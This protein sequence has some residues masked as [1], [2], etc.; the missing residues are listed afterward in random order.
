MA[1]VK[2]ENDDGDSFGSDTWLSKWANPEEYETIKS[3]ELNLKK[4]DEHSATG[5]SQ[6]NLSNRD[7]SQKNYDNLNVYKY[8]Y[9]EKQKAQKTLKSTR[10]SR[11]KA[12]K[13]EKEQ[14]TFS[15]N[16]RKSLQ[17]AIEKATVSDT[18]ANR[19]KYQCPAC[20]KKHNTKLSLRH[21]FNTTKHV[22]ERSYTEKFLT[23]IVAYKCYLCSKKM[24]CDKSVIYHH[25][26]GKHKLPF[27]D[28]I[29]LP[30]VKV[31][32]KNLKKEKELETFITKPSN[33]LTIQ[34]NVGNFCKFSC[35]RCEYSSLTWRILERHLREKCNLSVQS[36][37]ECVTKV[38]LYKCKVCIKLLL[39]DTRIIA[40]HVKSHKMT[41]CEYQRRHETTIENLFEQYRLNLSTTVQNIAFFK[42]KEL[43]QFKS[44]P[45]L[46]TQIQ[47][48]KDTGNLT[49][50][51][52]PICST[53]CLSSDFF[54]RHRKRQHQMKSKIN[55]KQH[56]IEAPFH[57]CIIC[58]KAVLCDNTYVGHHVKHFHQLKL[59]Q[60]INKF[61]IKNGH[62]N[63]PTFGEYTYNHQ[64]FQMIKTSKKQEEKQEEDCSFILPEDLSSESKESG[65][66]K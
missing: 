9:Q 5:N 10:R 21:H 65:S 8:S 15:T 47:T 17:E 57:S 43:L 53:I 13:T 20:G 18:I 49:S 34:E 30:N 11:K 23:D 32:G 64:V 61:V 36:P 38:S 45:N 62:R 14:R 55:P 7:Q 48:T 29:K 37:K 31:E 6:K 25:V 50:F 59:S 60:Y 51:S 40:N 56:V 33:N 16:S 2:T 12:S 63:I 58:N 39:C 19:C 66:E 41:L 26:Y 3:E 52:C 46:L 24:A 27:L 1:M 44:N 28:Y 42:P 22:M 54:Q 35:P 4:E